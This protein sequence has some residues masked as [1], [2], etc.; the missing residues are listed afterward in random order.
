[1]GSKET[2]HKVSEK[3]DFLCKNKDLCENMVVLLKCEG[4]KLFCRKGGN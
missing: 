4:G 1:M 3:E 2:L